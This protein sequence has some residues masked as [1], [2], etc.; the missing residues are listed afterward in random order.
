MGKRTS[1]AISEWCLVLIIALLFDLAPSNF[2]FAQSS[3][4]QKLRIATKHADSKTFDPHFAVQSQDR[5]IAGMIFNGLLRYPPGNLT[6]DA[7]E[8]DLATS[9][10]VPKLE[11]DGTQTW[12][13]NLKK[14]VMTH[15][16]EGS[17]G[18]EITSEDVVYSFKR[19]SDKNRSAYSADYTGMSFETIDTYSLKIS[20][21]KPLSSYLFFPLITNRGG[22]LIVSKKALDEKG[23]KWFRSNPV[24]TGPFAFQTYVPMEKVILSAHNKYFRGKPNLAAVEFYYMEN[25][26]SREL[27]LQKGEVDVVYGPNEPTWKKKIEKIDGVVVGVPTWG[28]TVVIHMNMSITPLNVLDVRKAIAYALDRKVFQALYGADLCQVIYS[29]IPENVGGIQKEE[30]IKNDLIYEYDVLK[31]KELLAKAGYPNGFSLNVFTSQNDS[32]KPAYELLQ[33]SLA[34]INIKMELSVEDHPSWHERIRKNLDPFV[35]YVC[36]RPNPDAILTQFYYSQSIVLTGEK[37]V[38]NFSHIGKI[39]ANGDGKIDSIDEY[40]LKAKN[41]ASTEIQKS[42]WNEAQKEILK[43]MVAYPAV[44]IDSPFAWKTYVDWGYK[45]IAEADGLKATEKTRIAK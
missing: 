39:D 36:Q 40:I 10:P 26:N 7:I 35:I 33:N 22:G 4:N 6:T 2:A 1:T 12:V 45:V 28:E 15:P 38:T 44:A 17:S 25:L 14:G 43:N 37:P 20:L 16:Y 31:A 29:P 8:P 23:D 32:I 24:G 41:E 5:V 11:K 18:Y 30:L 3:A 13:I 34:K 19:A 42:L 27:A 21:A 9:L